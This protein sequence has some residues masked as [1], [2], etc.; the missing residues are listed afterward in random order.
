M[1]DADYADRFGSYYDYLLIDEEPV[2]KQRAG[3]GGGDSG[4]QLEALVRP[5]P[6]RSTYKSEPMI[7]ALAKGSD[8]SFSKDL[9]PH[10]S[11]SQMLENALFY[12]QA[13]E[14]I[15][16]LDTIGA[17]NP[18]VAAMPRARPGKEDIRQRRAR[19]AIASRE[20][21]NI[22]TPSTFI[23]LPRDQ[24]ARPPPMLPQERSLAMRSEPEI[25]RYV[26]ESRPSSKA[27]AV[28]TGRHAKTSHGSANG[29]NSASA[30]SGSSAV[31]IT[32]FLPR[33]TG[34]AAGAMSLSRPPTSPLSVSDSPSISMSLARRGSDFA[35]ESERR[36]G[37]DQPVPS[38][39]D[40]D[41]GLKQR[42]AESPMT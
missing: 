20:M 41:E 26:P 39:S 10:N 28:Q 37:F 14:Q 3:G 8:T 4:V 23:P 2:S 29:S 18:Y 22:T 7:R 5:P 36:A 42:R 33:S 31:P 1:T 32:R 34:P 27:V 21:F 11:Y 6:L 15:R 35:H 38:S 16:E 24:F 25:K 30:S 19:N 40:L 9:D 12:S 17:S 13:I